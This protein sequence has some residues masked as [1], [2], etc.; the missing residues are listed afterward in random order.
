MGKT[1][2]AQ[3]LE[4]TSSHGLDLEFAQVAERPDTSKCESRDQTLDQTLRHQRMLP[5]RL[6][7][8]IWA[9]VAF[10]TRAASLQVAL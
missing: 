7:L 6:W 1:E 2:N 5:K 4:K 3:Q 8:R 9:K 10:F